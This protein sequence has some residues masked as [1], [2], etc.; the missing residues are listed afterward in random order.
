[1]LQ[2]YF[3]SVCFSRKEEF[4]LIHQISKI[5]EAEHS[6]YYFKYKCSRNINSILCSLSQVQLQQQLC[7]RSVVFLGNQVWNLNISLDSY[8]NKTNIN[9][10]VAHV[11]PVPFQLSK[12]HIC[13]SS[14][15]N[16]RSYNYNL[17]EL[18]KIMCLKPWYWFHSKHHGTF[19]SISVLHDKPEICCKSQV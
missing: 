3:T 2:H 15:Q 7:Y 1:M 14:T 11:Y 8:R 9:L 19:L 6:T 17:T 13:L 18:I 12:T 16:S 5:T 10:R 4:W